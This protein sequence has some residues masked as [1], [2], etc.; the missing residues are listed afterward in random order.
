MK[1][2]RMMIIGMLVAIGVPLVLGLAIQGILMGGAF[3]ERAQRLRLSG[4]G[5]W[6][7]GL[8]M[9]SSYCLA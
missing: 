4:G 9:S 8:R 3:V 6:S 7:T 5:V 2:L 1:R